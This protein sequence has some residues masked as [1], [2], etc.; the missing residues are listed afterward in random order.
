VSSS[1]AATVLYNQKAFP[2]ET[3]RLFFTI[4]TCSPI[5]VIG[6]ASN[7]WC[8]TDLFRSLFVDISHSSA[9]PVCCTG[10][11]YVSLDTTYE[12]SVFPL[13]YPPP[14]RTAS[15]SSAAPHSPVLCWMRCRL[16]WSRLRLLDSDPSSCGCWGVSLGL[17]SSCGWSFKIESRGR[18]GR[19]VGCSKCEWDERARMDGMKQNGSGSAWDH[20]CESLLRRA[21]VK[22]TLT[23]TTN[24]CRQFQAHRL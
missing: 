13:P 10:N 4:V 16:I 17:G 11:N 24:L 1:F 19:G 22:K 2:D 23:C 14:C 12:A 7:S 20:V 6:T 5:T 8:V 3:S 18:T 9:R 21:R 15:L